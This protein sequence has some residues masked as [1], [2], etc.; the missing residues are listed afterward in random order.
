MIDTDLYGLGLLKITCDQLYLSACKRI[1][2][3]KYKE[4][5]FLPNL[6]CDHIYIDCA[7]NGRKKWLSI[8]KTIIMKWSDRIELKIHYLKF[9]VMFD[10]D[11]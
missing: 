3:M 5:T 6:Q 10:L 8:K 7:I 1:N 11:A 2:E 9:H 4:F